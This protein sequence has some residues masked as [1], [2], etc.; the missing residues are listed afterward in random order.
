MIKP[1]IKLKLDLNLL[2]NKIS[3]FNKIKYVILVNVPKKAKIRIFVFFKNIFLNVIELFF[4][5]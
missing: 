2:I 1:T 3:I 4:V 5:I